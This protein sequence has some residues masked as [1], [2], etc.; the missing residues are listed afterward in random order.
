MFTDP[1]SHK[2]PL[3]TCKNLF[4][5]ICGTVHKSKH[6]QIEQQRTNKQ[7]SYPISYLK[8]E[9]GLL[10]QDAV[11]IISLRNT[12]PVEVGFGPRHCVRKL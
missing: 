9:V 2:T 11:E 12:N 1:V 4:D 6:K 10:I 5:E 8:S 7:Y 3:I